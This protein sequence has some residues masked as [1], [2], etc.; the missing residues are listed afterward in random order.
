MGS[1]FHSI[2]LHAVF[3]CK[4]RRPLIAPVIA[5]RLYSY[6]GGILR[7][8]G[9]LLIEGGGVEDHAHLL[10]GFAPK[11]SVAEVLRD[12]KANS[13]RWIH[14][15]WPDHEFGWQEGYGV[16]SVSVSHIDKTKAYIRNQA[17][18]HAKHTLEDELRDFMKLHGLGENGEPMVGMPNEVVE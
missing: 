12:I 10:I 3:A 17:Q 14:E 11:N 7:K 18:H 9:C 8:R 15:T 1:T 13:S 2:T 6:L 16:F 5:S 4:D